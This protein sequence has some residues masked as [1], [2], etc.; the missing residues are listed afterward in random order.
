MSVKSLEARLVIS[1]DD[2]T[3][4]A[5]GAVAAKLRNLEQI[6]RSVRPQMEAIRRASAA[7]NQMDRVSRAREAAAATRSTTGTVLGAVASYAA[8][9]AIAAAAVSTAADSAKRFAEVE[10]AMTRVALTAGATAQE[11]RKA[12]DD[13]AKLAIDTAMP[14]DNARKGLEALVSQG[15]RL[16]EA[17]ALLPSVV[18]T[19]QAAGAEADDIAKTAGA[20]GTQLQV[21]AKDMQRAFDLLVEGGN[22]GQFELK[23]MARYLPS[24]A[25]AAAAIGFKGEEGLKQ[26]VT[27]LQV[28]RRGTG[29]AEE[30]AGSAQNIFAKM[31]SDET[32]KRFKEFGV[33]LEEQLKKARAE[34]RNLLQVFTDLTRTAVNGDLSKIPRLFADMEF[35]RGMRAL[36]VGSDAAKQFNRELQNFDGSTLKQLNRVLSD[37]QANIDRM[38]ASW[39]R[40]KTKFGEALSPT[41]VPAMDALSKL[42]NDKVT[43]DQQSKETPPLV[44]LTNEARRR[45]EAA[46]PGGEKY[47]GRVK[48]LKTL[49]AGIDAEPGARFMAHTRARFASELAMLQAIASVYE[50]TAERLEKLKSQAKLPGQTAITRAEN[51][52]AGSLAPGYGR[53]AFNTGGI[54]IGGASNNVGYVPSYTLPPTRANV[55]TPPE[56]RP[57]SSAILQKLDDVLGPGKIE[58]KVSGA[59]DI[60]VSITASPLLVASVTQQV[61]QAL[62]GWSLNSVGSTGRSAPDLDRRD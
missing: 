18:R 27:T 23:D 1:A 14:F 57:E 34:G 59:A 60:S 35:A 56:G 40:L 33:D 48:E 11:A 53:L 25:A 41:I 62:V 4:D 2:K 58:A 22:L 61:K 29:T 38:A 42:L 15:M 24:M 9:A 16:P 5:F 20:L 30:A 13:V 54:G 8:P 6:T 19:A 21:G 46:L 51:T 43:R 45:R 32:V 55:P 31:E 10:R 17:M 50:E 37:S 39:D 44:Q 52:P 7:Q 12:T 3:G 49:I 26:L 28:I 47:T 36:L